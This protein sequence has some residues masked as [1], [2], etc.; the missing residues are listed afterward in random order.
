MKKQILMA[1]AVALALG[2]CSKTETTGTAQGGV[3]GFAGSGVNNITKAEGKII[4]ADEFNEFWVYGGYGDN[5]VFNG[6]R[7]T[8]S[9]SNWTY[10]NTQYWQVGTWKFA[11]YAP[12]ATGITPTWDNANGL[13]LE[14]ISD[15]GNQNDLVYAATTKDIVINDDNVNTYDTKVSLTFNHLLS[16]IKFGFTKGNSVAGTTVELYNFKVSG[17]YSKGTWTAGV[18]DSPL[19]QTTAEYTDFGTVEDDAEEVTT[20][21]GLSTQHYFVI[22]QS[23]GTFNISFQAVVTDANGTEIRAGEVTATVPTTYPIWNAKKAYLYKAEIEM[24]NIKDDENPMPKP[25]EFTA[26]ASNWETPTNE[27]NVE[28]KDATTQEP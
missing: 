20:E 5:A 3:I 15:M 28:L 1:A 23:V 13:K 26:S 9:S 19:D 16:Q 12:Q 11:G 6:E 18:L 7:V 24:E 21:D 27:T 22:P 14:V 2:G 8:K 10:T 4:T 25:I 17:I